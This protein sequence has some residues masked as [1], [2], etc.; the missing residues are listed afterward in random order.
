[1]CDKR[2]EALCMQ[3][4]PDSEIS[5]RNENGLVHI[6]E[7]DQPF[8]ERQQNDAGNGAQRRSVRRRGNPLKMVK[9]YRRSVAGV[10][11]V[12]PTE[13]RPYSVL[14]DTITYLLR[15]VSEQ[16][17]Q[18][19]WPH[20][21]E[22]VS[23]RLRAV[24][25]DMVV[26]SLD[27]ERGI[28]LL[29]AMIPFYVEAE[30]RCEFTRCPTYDRK[31][32]LTQLEE[33]FF[34]WRQLVDF[35]P[36]KNERIMVSYLLHTASERWSFMQ[37]IG[38]KKYFCERNYRFIKDVILALHMNN[39]VRFFRLVSQQNDYL[40]RLTL[41]RFFG[42]VRLLALRA[43]AVAYRCRGAALPEK[44]LE[45]VLR[46]DSRNLRFCLGELGLKATDGKVCS[47][48]ITLKSNVDMC[49]PEWIYADFVH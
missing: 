35:F 38:W 40:F 41:V 6:L 7:M 9:E 39:F 24:R 5:F 48:G 21:Y 1:M 26:E 49:S 12:K 37:L 29:E 14:M 31:L 11:K 4:C 15:I 43:C 13:L 32:H 36:E 10:E 3:M 18:D 45:D 2:P 22:F 19:T 28:R 33:C 27:V 8:A 30:Y 25:Q 16:P 46:M 17:C 23:D 34:R 20:V 47:F 42:P 44:F